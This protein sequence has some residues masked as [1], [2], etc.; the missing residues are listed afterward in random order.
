MTKLVITDVDGTLVKDGT[1]DINPEY[2]TVME[3]LIDKGIRV[4]IASGRPYAS[5]RRL[6]EPIWDKLMYVTDGGAVIRNPKQILK[7]FSLDTEIWMGAFEDAQK[8]KDTD[9]FIA[10]PE[11]CFA[12]DHT[13]EMFHWLVNSY[14]FGLTEKSFYEL[15]DYDV[16][17]FSVYHKED[18]E[19][20]CRAEYTPKWSQK[21]NITVAGKEWVDCI[22]K[23]ATKGNALKWLLDYWKIPKEETI[24]FGDNLNDID[25]LMA[26]GNSY[27]AGNARA[28]VKAA[29]RHV[30]GAYYEDGVLTVLKKIL[31][32][33]EV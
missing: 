17:K 22:H 28:E 24:A 3:Q 25:M 2:F 26:A 9:Y 29:A 5:I 16:I 4:V 14:G 32:G 30:A 33:E 15:K 18:C 31:A 19:G 20:I 13:T 11:E 1:L 10:T 6:F 7:S 8:L 21:A 12:Q 23:D 27:A